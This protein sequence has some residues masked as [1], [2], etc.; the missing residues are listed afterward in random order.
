M[1]TSVLAFFSKAESMILW[2]VNSSTT[3]PD[4][5]IQNESLPSKIGIDIAENGHLKGLQNR[6]ILK[7]L[8][9]KK[10]DDK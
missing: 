2:N 8:D 6:D 5:R 3:D 7:S 9:G 10:D 1:R 4:D